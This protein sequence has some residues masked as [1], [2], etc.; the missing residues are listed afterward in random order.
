MKSQAVLLVDDDPQIKRLV[1]DALANSEFRLLV[2][3]NACEAMRLL[4][5]RGQDICIVI[6]ELAP[7][8]QGLTLLTAVKAWR[9]DLPFIILT[10]FGNWD[11]YA[12]AMAAGVSEFL[13]KPTEVPALRAALNRVWKRTSCWACAA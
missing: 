13:T 9:N 4:Q 5:V 7:L 2:A 8:A 10:A 12:E 11:V 3:P 1:A 6:A